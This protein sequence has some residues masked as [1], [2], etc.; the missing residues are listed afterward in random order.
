MTEFI[1]EYAIIM[2][3]LYTIGSI[4]IMNKTKIYDVANKASY[5]TKIKI[6]KKSRYFNFTSIKR[7]FINT[8]ISYYANLDDDISFYGIII[9]NAISNNK[10]YSGHILKS[11]SSFKEAST[12]SRLNDLEGDKTMTTNEILNRLR[13]AGKSQ[14]QN[15]L[16]KYVV[17]IATSRVKYHF[18]REYYI[19]SETYLLYDNDIIIFFKK[20]DNKFND[21]VV[22]KDGK[23]TDVN[24]YIALIPYDSHTFVYVATKNYV[25]FFLENKMDNDNQNNNDV[26][27]Y[28]FGRHMNKITSRFQYCIDHVSSSKGK[29][30]S[31]YVVNS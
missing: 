14:A 9:G 12:D 3:Y 31:L 15:A 27:I 21:H 28:V 6:N 19:S 24:A 11:F 8:T 1:T 18:G 20:Y 4:I 5:F 23:M 22:F 2:I 25:P 7:Y 26:Y 30:D 17:P 13:E 16:N 29:G 10:I